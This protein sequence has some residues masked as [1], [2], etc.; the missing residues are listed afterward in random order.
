MCSTPPKPQTSS[1]TTKTH[2]TINA[3]SMLVLLLT[4]Q[5]GGVHIELR[6]ILSLSEHGIVALEVE[7]CFG[8]LKPSVATDARSHGTQNCKKTHPYGQES[9]GQL[10]PIYSELVWM[11]SGPVK[12][13]CSTL[14]AWRTP[15]P[16]R[17]ARRDHYVRA[18]ATVVV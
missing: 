13:A 7:A 8:R 6:T 11:C 12:P 15:V 18:S 17:I 9:T 2:H 5:R 1:N 3:F 10:D 4:P 14:V 16:G